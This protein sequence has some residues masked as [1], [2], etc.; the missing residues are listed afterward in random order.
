MKALIVDKKGQLWIDP[1]AVFADHQSLLTPLRIGRDEQGY[2]LLSPLDTSAIAPA[3]P[4]DAH[5]PIRL[6][7][8]RYA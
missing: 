7:K 6:P 2:I 3:A 8:T 4:K 5:I 1:D